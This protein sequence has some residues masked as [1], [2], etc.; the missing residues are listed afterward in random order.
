M[1]LLPDVC[2]LLFVPDS[3]L[4]TSDFFMFA[5][6]EAK[7]LAPFDSGTESALG[8]DP[9]FYPGGTSEQ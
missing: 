1:T 5:S 9:N 3:L 7:P 4:L 8:C 2:P 6:N